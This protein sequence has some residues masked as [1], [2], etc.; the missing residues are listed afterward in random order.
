MATKRKHAEAH[1]LR[2]A[3]LQRG[4]SMRA[5]HRIS[6]VNHATISSIENRHR[7]GTLETYRKL[8][9]ALHTDYRLLMEN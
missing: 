5:L 1:P 2:K 8:A 3:R 4:Y 9:R 6:G 7:G